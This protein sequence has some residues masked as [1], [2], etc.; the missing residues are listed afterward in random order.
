M[1]LLA[2]VD[3]GIYNILTFS[4]G[5]KLYVEESESGRV[6][7]SKGTGDECRLTKSCK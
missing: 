5:I 2:D 7:L 1:C 6:S 4:S 3:I